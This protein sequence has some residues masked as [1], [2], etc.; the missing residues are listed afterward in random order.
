MITNEMKFDGKFVVKITFTIE[1]K[2]VKN[3]M[4][5]RNKLVVQVWNV[6]T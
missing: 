1:K 4:N 3:A 5:T 6:T 2:L